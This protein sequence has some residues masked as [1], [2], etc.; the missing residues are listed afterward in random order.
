MAYFRDEFVR[1][2]RWLDEGTF[3]QCVALTQLLPGPASSQTGMLIGWLRAG[4][5]G[6]VA[7]W[8]G[9]TAPSAALM[10]GLALAAP[11]LPAG[12]VHALLVVATAVVAN[13]VV[14]MRV[15]LAPDARRLGLALATFAAVL[16]VRIPQIGPLAIAA[17]ALAGAAL[18]RGSVEPRA[19]TLNLRVS[20]RAGAVA[21]VAFAAAIVALGA[22][23][24]ATHAPAWQLAAVLFR[25]GSLVFGGGHVVLPLLQSQLAA[26]GMLSNSSLLAGY[27]AAQAMPGP[28][29][30][31]ASY[32]GAAAFG[33]ALGWRGALLGTV[34]I[35]APSFFLLTGVAPFYRRLSESRDVRA[36]IAG[37]NASVV[38]LLAAA[39]VTPI[40]T[41][42]LHT[43]IDAA[44]AATAFAALAFARVPSWLL[45]AIAVAA[46]AAFAR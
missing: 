28:L 33:G 8:I 10:A 5:A 24:R 17:S 46:G 9:F 40:A 20:P 31:I 38:G 18:F 14:S 12:P 25:V 34:A 3:A 30:T 41:S 26:A 36:A 37:A 44:A 13:A 2:R 29:F 15:A 19:A 7:A 42:A 6:A 23:A 27:A 39:L 21:F 35:F 32:A 22:A 11:S 1:R 45:V 4:P 43:W 16:L